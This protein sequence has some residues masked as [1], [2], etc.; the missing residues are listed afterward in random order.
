LRKESQPTDW[1]AERFGTIRVAPRKTSTA[2]VPA[3]LRELAPLVTGT[4]DVTRTVK[5]G[6]KMSLRRGFDFVV[7]VGT[8]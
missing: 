3:R 2:L 1:G 7:N 8:G 4:A 6:F 5:L